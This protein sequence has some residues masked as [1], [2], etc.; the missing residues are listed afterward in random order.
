[1]SALTGTGELVRLNLRRDRVMLPAW[2]AALVVT[3][4]GSVA[5]TAQ[6]YPTAQS[7]E[8][9]A[10]LIGKTPAVVALYGPATDLGTLGGLATWKPNTM[11]AVL[12]A[13]MSMLIVVRHT[14]ADEEA[15]RL[16][17]VG[18]G[19]VG[20]YAAL[21]AALVVAFGTNLVLAALMAVS[22]LGQDL[23][24][25]GVVALALGFGAVGWMFAAIAAAA[26]QL[27][28]SSRTANGITA[29][30]LGLA[31]LLRAAGDTAGESGPSWLTWLS[32]IGWV[33]K[34]RPFGDLHWWPLLLP[35]GLVVL[36]TTVAYL[37][38]GQRD[39]AAGL[40]PPRRGPAHAAPTLNSPLTLAWRL[41][42]GSLLAWTVG[43][44]IFGSVAGSVASGVG[45]LVGDN[46]QMREFLQRMGGQQ[47]LVDA[48]LATTMGIM[49]IVAT[50]YAVQAAL[51][52]RVEE[53]AH[54][55][56]P[57]LATPVGRIR[58]ALSHFGIAVLGPAVLLAAAGLTI[59]T[60]HGARTG[61]IGD[62]LPRILGSA[63][64]Q[65]P[66]VWVVAGITL[67]AFGLVPRFATLGWAALVLFLLLT[68]LGP[69]LDLDKR[70]L[71]VSPFRHVPQL[72]VAEFA[73]TPPLALV[74]VALVLTAAG[75]VGLRRR[76]LG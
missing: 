58:W 5:S 50:A 24:I 18:A 74:G 70:L 72:P 57:L 23:P 16:E 41:H 47:T 55:V 52:L 44:V 22:L 35:L 10:V 73:V 8:Q 67:A 28:E 26:A 30:A 51:R 7:R 53:N 63:L 60:A 38:A 19:V 37:L 9:A 40:L 12:I 43:F 17:L 45:E 65:L 39:L 46:P 75:L 29:S 76:D 21:T 34:L 48:Y 4:Y 6:L 61:S 11:L 15:G 20:R 69:V 14:R 32:P 36:A 42:R 49:A 56:E 68:E 59:G 1:M 13:V 31:F 25:D 27:T 3:L 64:V 54:R 66:A 2:L 33:Q 71:D 62:Q